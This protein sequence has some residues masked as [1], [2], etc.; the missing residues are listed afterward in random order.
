MSRR[1]PLP[2]VSVRLRTEDA[3][4]LLRVCLDQLD[5]ASGAS[6]WVWWRIAQA[7]SAALQPQE[8]GRHAVVDRHAP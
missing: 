3:D 7:C 2:A 5:A 6:R 8:G 4:E 1:P